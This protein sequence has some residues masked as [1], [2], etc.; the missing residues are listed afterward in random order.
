MPA[1]R[2]R[3]K[4]RARL[5]PGCQRPHYLAGERADETGEMKR[6]ARERARAC[7]GANQNRVRMPDVSS[8]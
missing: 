8:T 4:Q 7:F 2:T 5:E 1:R 6:A 3:G